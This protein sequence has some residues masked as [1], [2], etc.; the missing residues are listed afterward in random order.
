MFVWGYCWWENGN[1]TTESLPCV[2]RSFKSECTKQIRKKLNNP[3]II[4]WQRNYRVY[5][6]PR[7]KRDKLCRREY[8][9][10]NP[11]KSTSG[12][13]TWIRTRDP[14]DVTSERSSHL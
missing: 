6:E 3:N 1:V 14:S 7:L 13:H 9:K 10:T 8:I 4:V 12:G 5:H 11:E 2:I